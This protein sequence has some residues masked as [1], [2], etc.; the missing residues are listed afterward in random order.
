MEEKKILVDIEINSEDIKKAQDAMS[1]SAKSA[2]L[3][4]L[5]LNKLKEEQKEN[6]KLFKD[7]KISAT[8]LASRQAALKLQM[9]ETS[10]ALSASNKDYANNKVVVDAANGSNE[11]LR[12]RLALQTKEYN[13]LSKAQRENTKEGKQMEANISTLTEKLKGNEKAVGDNRRNVGNYEGALEKTNKSLDKLG[14]SAGKLPGPLGAMA[15]GIVGATKASL[16]F[17]A[18]PL[19]LVLAAVA[20]AIG[21]VKLAFAS[22][23]EGQNKWNKIVT[24]GSALIGNFTDLIADF[25]EKIIEAF[26][27]PQQAV[28]DFSTLIQENIINRFNGLIELVPALGRSIE[29]L[30]KGNIAEAG[31]IAADATAKVA[32]GVENITEKT[33]GAI[34]GTKAFIAEQEKELAQAAQVADMR[35]KADIVERK[36][37]VDRAKAEAEVADLRLRA[38]KEDEFTA[39]ER[40]VF[41]QEANKIQNELLDAETEYLGL[42]ADAQILENTFSKTNKENKNLEAQAVAALS[43][44]ETKRFT[45]Q[46][47]LQRELNTITNQMAAES[48]AQAASKKKLTEDEIKLEAERVVAITQGFEDQRTLI[49]E[50]AETQKNLAIIN[51]SDAEE[52]AE[53]IAFIEREALNAKLMSIDDETASYTAAAGMVGAVDEVKYAKQLEQRAQFEA[54]RAEMDRAANDREF[55]DAMKLSS[56]KLKLAE[57]QAGNEIQSTEELEKK[58]N[59]LRLAALQEQLALTKKFFGELSEEEQIQLDTLAAMI[60]KL[61]VQASTP[62]EESGTLANGLG[63]DPEG[64]EKAQAAFETLQAGLNAVS[65]I[66]NNQAETQLNNLDARTQAEIASVERS[67]LNEED[68][69]AKIKAIEKKSAQEE[70]VIKKKQF[71]ANQKISITQA[72]IAG[73]LGVVNAFQLGPIA[74]AIAALFIAATTVTQVAAISSAKPPPAPKFAKGGYISGAGTGTSDSIDAKLS[75]GESVNTARATKMFGRE[76]SAMNAAGGGVDWY[77]KGSGHSNRFAVGGIVSPTF[78]ARQT[79][80]VAGLTANDLSVALAE[81][82]API[83]TVSDIN[84]V[85]GQVASVS[86]SAN[87]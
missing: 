46:R 28:R 35:A 7:Q 24:V 15:Q 57:L 78:A 52:R 81:M 18:T 5:E 70:Y 23:E 34:E 62:S 2:A 14:A 64:L 58:K 38:R 16:A 86:G 59:A 49:D 27:N 48:M 66:V 12:A 43:Q 65:Q 21:A 3:L 32:L 53:K 10:K 4:T 74:G 72:I 56:D 76:I 22:S 9:T 68:K 80:Q 36:L 84:R 44:I 63:I 6:N 26:E 1:N 77:K 19:G 69:A 11:Q 45:E 61:K 40:K 79:A 73:A 39:S 47:Q 67:T 30:F 17:I 51:I 85:Q 20:L 41:L 13:G 87:L 50:M 83:V 55:N 33:K 29:Q 31:K 8:E 54:E 82:P 37:L 25:G 75:H 42:R 71:E 60:E